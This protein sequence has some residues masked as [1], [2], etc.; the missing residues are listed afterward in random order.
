MHVA[1]FKTHEPDARETLAWPVPNQFSGLC[2]AHNL[3]SRF[4]HI[5][6]DSIAYELKQ[7]M[8]VRS[9]GS[10]SNTCLTIGSGNSVDFHDRLGVLCIYACKCM[11]SLPQPLIPLRRY[12]TSSGRRIRCQAPELTFI[13]CTHQVQ[14]SNICKSPSI[15]ILRMQITG[16]FKEIKPEMAHRGAMLILL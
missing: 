3:R 9:S 1:L 2:A 4:D 10:Q 8:L 16:A 6:S 5:C 13:H 12:E 11:A 15:P 7:W 14:S